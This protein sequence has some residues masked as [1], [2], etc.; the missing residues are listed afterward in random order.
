MWIKNSNDL[1]HSGKK[2]MKWGYNDGK[3]NGKRT[4][5]DDVEKYIIKNGKTY[6][7]VEIDS[8]GYAVYKSAKGNEDYIKIRNSN[9]LLSETGV[10][11]DSHTNTET[12]KK[13]VTRIETI[14]VGKIDQLSNKIVKKVDAFLDKYATDVITI[15][16]E[17]YTPSRKNGTPKR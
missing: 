11:S 1:Y 6:K 5:G 8:N 17:K 10:R 12:G 15:N 7:L 13:Y 4:A 9:S 3:R 16:G 2:G 14:E